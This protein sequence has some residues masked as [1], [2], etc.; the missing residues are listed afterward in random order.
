MLPQIKKIL[1]ATDLSD[2]A[3]H[4]FN[5]AALL[6]DRLDAEITVMHVIDDITWA[7]KNLL[8][9]FLGEKKLEELKEHK[10]SKYLETITERIEAFCDESGDQLK[11]CRY[12]V[13]HRLIKEG[14]P[15]EEILEEAHGSDY[16]MVIIGTH[17]LGMMANALMGDTARRVVRRCHKP[18][19]V[20]RLPE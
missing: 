6:A 12:M 20:I 16:D 8:V 4:A 17:G 14:N 7:G 3:R 19:T 15:A 11:E 2:S 9:D 5:Y 10:K 13:R 1:Y 18:V